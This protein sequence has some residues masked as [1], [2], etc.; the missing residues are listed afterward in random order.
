MGGALGISVGTV[1]LIGDVVCSARLPETLTSGPVM[2]GNPDDLINELPNEGE[3]TDAF[4]T[5][6]PHG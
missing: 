2:P 4:W 6:G 1:P 5:R 3:G